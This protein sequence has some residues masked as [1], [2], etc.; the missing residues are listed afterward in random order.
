MTTKLPAAHVFL[1]SG[2]TLQ[3]IIDAVSLAIEYGV[4]TGNS[5]AVN[6]TAIN[7]AIAACGDT[8][9][10]VVPPSCAYNE[11]DLTMVDGVIVMVW[12]TDGTVMLLTKDQ[13]TSLPVTKGGLV[14][15]SK[16]NTGIL[17]RTLDYGVSAEPIVQVLDA[18]GGDI[19]AIELKNLLFGETADLTAPSA[20]KA[21]LYAR[22]DGSGNTQLAVRFPTGNPIYL[23]AENRASNLVGTATYDPP[24]LADGAG[25]TT[26]VTVTGAVLGDTVITSFSLD[27]QG[28]TLTSYVSSSNTVS[29]RF[30][31]E[32]GGALD[33]AS[34]T[35]KSV[36]LR[37][38]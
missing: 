5:A 2:N 22:D 26:T 31:N 29:V 7:D 20:N 17:L 11:V 35:L 21:K 6:T 15:K 1:P 4:A 23:A 12:S 9:F 24:N 27:L 14:I 16:G 8:G 10:V 37:N 34:G 3:T 13:G 38:Y 19:A 32:S 36:V 30:Q 33:L 18:T 28:I 25:A